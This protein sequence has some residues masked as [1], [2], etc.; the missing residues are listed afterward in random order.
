VPHPDEILNNLC[1]ANVDAISRKLRH[2]RYTLYIL[3]EPLLRNG[4]VT[5]TNSCGLMCGGKPLIIIGVLEH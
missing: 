5:R 2:F 3:H 1:R 4:L